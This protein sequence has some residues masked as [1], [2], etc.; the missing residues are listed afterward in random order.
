MC[1]P[2][3]VLCSQAARAMLVTCFGLVAVDWL[4]GGGPSIAVRSLQPTVLTLALPQFVL[5][6]TYSLHACTQSRPGS[7]CAHCCVIF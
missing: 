1:V 7:L 4:L 3:S 2:Q 6:T 5:L